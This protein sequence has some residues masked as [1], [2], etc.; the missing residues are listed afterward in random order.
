MW[1][2]SKELGINI[3]EVQFLSQNYLLWLVDSVPFVMGLLAYFVGTRHEN[4][5]IFNSQLEKQVRARTLEIRKSKE[6]A[7]RALKTKSNFLANMSHEIRTPMNGVIGITGLLMDTNLSSEQHDYVDTIRDCGQNLLT[8]INDILDF[9]KMEAGKLE[10]EEQPFDIFKAIES[11][12]H[13]LEELAAK[14]GL[15]LNYTAT[16]RVPT[17]IQGDVTRLRQIVVNL[18]SNAIKFTEKGEISVILDAEELIGDVFKI[19]VSVKDSGIGIPKDRLDRLFQSFSQVDASTT[20]LYG[21]S[22]LGLVI[23]RRLAEMMGGTMWVES[24]SGQGSTF[25]FNIVAVKLELSSEKETAT[26][27]AKID[28]ELAAKFPLKI[29]LAE[30]NIVNQKVALKILGKMGYRADLAANGLE[31]LSALKRQ[32]YDLIFMDMQ[33]PEMDGL[34]AT[35]QVRRD[36]PTAEQPTII[37][38]TASAMKSDVDACLGAGMNS[39]ISKPV[40][41]DEIISHLRKVK[42]ITKGRIGIISQEI[43]KSEAVKDIKLGLRNTSLRDKLL[44]NFEGDQEILNIAVESYFSFFQPCLSEIRSAVIEKNAPALYKAAHSLKG[45]VSNFLLDGV[46]EA[47]LK[48]ETMG[49]NNDFTEIAWAMTQLEAGIEQLNAELAKLRQEKVA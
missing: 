33:M 25:H 3:S 40:G 47:V 11:S 8:I 41:L 1:V 12:L 45:A 42:R 26:A 19:Q 27:D 39:F 17:G 31:V 22:G 10:L 36:W 43:N 28:H 48:L 14:K 2:R 49:R 9:S 5:E 32:S 24:E 30:D 44:K 35:R 21:G 20:R 18:V 46:T 16:S 4:L 29:L 23:S 37:A 7:E 13:L 15:K 34:E 6:V 38:M